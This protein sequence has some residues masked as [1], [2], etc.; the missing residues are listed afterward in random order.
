MPRAKK[1]DE[2]LT[3]DGAIRLE[4]YARDL[5][6][7][8]KI[9]EKMGISVSTLYAWARK[10]PT[11]S[12]ALKDGKAPV[13]TKVENALLKA[14]LGYTEKVKKP[15]KVRREFVAAGKGRKIEDTI[16]YVD[17]EV[18]VP[19][20]PR[21]MIKWLAARKPETWGDKREVD[22]NMTG[23]ESAAILDEI[24]AR[25]A[26]AAMDDEETGDVRET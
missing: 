2:W 17:E 22:L 20:D 5:V 6:T 4:G 24:R 8:D 11:I 3:E 10:H 12:Q 26:A 15:M 23:G 1:I 21:A 13:D 9:A 19:G 7:D 18:Y 14:A 25:M 16:E